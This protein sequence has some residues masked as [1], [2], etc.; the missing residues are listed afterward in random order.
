MKYYCWEQYYD[1]QTKKQTKSDEIM[2]ARGHQHNVEPTDD[3]WDMCL[4]NLVEK[5]NT[6]RQNWQPPIIDLTRE[7]IENGAE[8]RTRSE[9]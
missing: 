8:K 4:S 7:T 6:I 9:H 2:Y 5:V 1:N 3:Q